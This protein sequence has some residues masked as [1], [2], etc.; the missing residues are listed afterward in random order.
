MK[1]RKKEKDKKK[2]R[3]SIKELEKK[4]APAPAIGKKPSIPG[5]YAPGTEY[6][7]ARRDNL[8]K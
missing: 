7:L 3:L 1:T 2:K 5:P 4:I 6:G 8:K